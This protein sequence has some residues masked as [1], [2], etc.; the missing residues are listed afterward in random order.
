MKI[1]DTNME[2]KD[3]LGICMDMLI[4]SYLG[5]KGPIALHMS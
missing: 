2:G 4:F 5:T 1:V 3:R